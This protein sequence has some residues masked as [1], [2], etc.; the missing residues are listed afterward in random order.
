MLCPGYEVRSS[1]AEFWCEYELEEETF[2]GTR[3]YI[4]LGGAGWAGAVLALMLALV[5]VTW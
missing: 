1:G 2:C 4:M 3:V 5:L